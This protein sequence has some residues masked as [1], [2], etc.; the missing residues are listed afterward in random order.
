[1]N[2]GRKKIDSVRTP[3]SGKKIG[4]DWMEDSDTRTNEGQKKTHEIDTIRIT[5]QT[6]I[7]VEEWKEDI[8][9]SMVTTINVGIM[10]LD[11]ATTIGG[12]TVATHNSITDET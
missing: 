4:M 5:L 9:T 7:K 12:T 6:T 11:V 8:L 1:M 10:T 2:D 3:V